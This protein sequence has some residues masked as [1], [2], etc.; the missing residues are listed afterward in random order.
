MT[1]H[2]PDVVKELDL[3]VLHYF[4]IEKVLGIP[5]KAQRTSDHID[6]DRS[7]S[8]CLSK[9]IQG[10]AQMAIR[11]DAFAGLDALTHDR[12]RPA[13][14]GDHDRARL[15]GRVRLDHEDVLPLLAGLD[16]LRGHHEGVGLGADR[17]RDRREL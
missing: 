7:F 10:Q 14:E 15:D 4:I 2:F 3:T 1:W 9:V 11:H 8:D 16:R 12:E 17:Q 5:G 13:R 6:F